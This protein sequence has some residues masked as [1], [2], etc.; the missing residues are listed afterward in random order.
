MVALQ[1]WRKALDGPFVGQPHVGADLAIAS[2]R[3]QS[4]ECMLLH[5]S[6][7]VWRVMVVMRPTRQ[8]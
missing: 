2:T 5:Q 8:T 6:G 7:D 4:L 1:D 3:F